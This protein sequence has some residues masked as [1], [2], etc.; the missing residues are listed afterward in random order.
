MTE[1]IDV[2]AE[3]LLDHWSAFL[4][5]EVQPLKSRQMQM[6]LE[7]RICDLTEALTDMLFI[8]TCFEEGG[9]SEY[10]PEMQVR[11]RAMK[12]NARSVFLS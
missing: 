3:T 6:A 5:R 11:L 4:P 7:K 8:W 10:P 1:P 9:L 12:D 2:V